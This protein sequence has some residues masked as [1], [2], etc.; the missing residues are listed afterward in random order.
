MISMMSVVGGGGEG[1]GDCSGDEVLREAVEG[2]GDWAGDGGEGVG[3]ATEGDG[4]AD[5]V[6]K[7]HR[8]KGAGDGFGDG[9]LAG[10]VKGV[11]GANLVHGAREV[12]AVGVL[13]CPSDLRRSGAP[14]AKPDGM[15]GGPCALHPLGMVVG[16]GGYT[17]GSLECFFDWS[18][19]IQVRSRGDPH[20][21]PVPEAPVGCW[22]RPFDPAG[23]HAAVAAPRMAPAPPLQGG[24]DGRSV[25]QNLRD[26]CGA[27]GVV[28]V[29]TLR[30][31]EL[32][33][34][35]LDPVPLVH[36]AHDVP[37][38][39][40]PHRSIPPRWRLGRRV[41]T[42]SRR[43]FNADPFRGRV[44]SGG[45]GDDG[46]TYPLRPPGSPSRIRLASP[47]TKSTTVRSRRNAEPSTSGRSGA[48]GGAVRGLAAEDSQPV[49]EVRLGL[50][51]EQ[52][53]DDFL[54][55]YPAQF[56]RTER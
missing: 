5:R 55:G 39:G 34:L 40:T 26:R 37:D 49:A 1:G 10:L 33:V 36:R 2:F 38:N 11:A 21:R 25:Q 22:F 3:V 41:A 23:E 30:S 4:V 9:P 52:G 31:E 54:V 14:K 51:L 20:C 46:G 50:A 6:F 56:P 28:G 32:E 8:F 7:A 17:I 47:V 35:R 44:R 48:G 53:I 16:H 15:R 13:D 12:V 42:S 29:L 27:D 45:V 18:V 19:S 43:G 24:R